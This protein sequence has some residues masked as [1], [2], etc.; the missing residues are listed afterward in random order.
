MALVTTDNA[1]AMSAADK[2]K[3]DTQDKI[4]TGTVPAF[5]ANAATIAPGT[6]RASRYALAS[7][8]TLAAASA[9]T[10]A[11]TGTPSVG[12]K[13]IMVYA[14][15][16]GYTLSIVNGGPAAGTVATFGATLTGPKGVVLYW[17][18]TNYVF[19]S[20]IEGAV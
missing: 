7:T 10:V 11:T 15:A 16:L 2:A 14:L 1:G 17:D 8:V 4:S 13:L 3:A 18:G 12:N 20:Y 19:S 5:V 9:L 6:D